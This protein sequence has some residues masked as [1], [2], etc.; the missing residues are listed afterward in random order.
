V[1]LRPLAARWDVPVVPVTDINQSWVLDRIRAL[2]PDIVF[3]IGWSQ[4]CRRAFLDAPARGAIGFHPSA[5]PRDR[6]RAVIPWTILQGRTETGATPFWLDEGVDSGDIICQERFSVAADET[7]ATLYAKH[8][9]ALARMLA[10][11]IP[12]LAGGETPRCPQDHRRATWCAR[13]DRQD[14]LIDWRAPAHDVHRL[15]RAVGDPYPGAFTYQAGRRLVLWSAELCDQRPYIGVPG[16]VQAM[17]GDSA[18][19]LCGDQRLL[20]LTAV[21]PDGQPR[22]A[23]SH[24]LRR[25]EKLGMDWPSLYERLA[26]VA[27]T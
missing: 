13:R 18:L 15:I 5:L 24:V 27:G 9:A 3:V 4:I 26:A 22:A 2:S 20:R 25:H 21:Q 17:E 1:D 11:A 7:A 23:A 10:G 19:V 12:V 14:G 6:G 8:L 16:Q